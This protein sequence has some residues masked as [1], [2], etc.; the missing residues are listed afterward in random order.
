MKTY[1]GTDLSF[2]TQIGIGVGQGFE[3]ATSNYIYSLVS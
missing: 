3:V 2:S 1:Q